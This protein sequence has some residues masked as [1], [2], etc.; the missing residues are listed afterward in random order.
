MAAG[1]F[2]I[3]V[4]PEDVAKVKKSYAGRPLGDLLGRRNS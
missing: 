2:R 1:W 4:R 3:G